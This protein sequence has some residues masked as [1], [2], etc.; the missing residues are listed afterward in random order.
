[1]I[2]FPD[3]PARRQSLYRIRYP[4]PVLRCN[5]I[6]VDTVVCL[7]EFNKIQFFF[8]DVLK[9]KREDQ[10]RGQQGNIEGNT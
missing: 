5:N 1:V 2:R 4:G 7:V 9:Q 6:E 8:I 3:R 10:F